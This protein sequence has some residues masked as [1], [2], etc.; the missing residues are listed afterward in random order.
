V[1]AVVVHGGLFAGNR[2]V[3]DTLAFALRG[4]A[5]NGFRPV[6]SDPPATLWARD[7]GTAERFDVQ[8]GP[9]VFCSGWR[10]FPLS[11]WAA[12]DRYAAFWV[13]GRALE[14]DVAAR[15]PISG[16]ISVDGKLELIDRIAEPRTLRF[17][18]GRAGWHL[19]AVESRALVEEFGKPVGIA[20]RAVRARR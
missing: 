17:E 10:F 2:F 15:V 8:P 12:R 13:Y 18:L 20:L 14:L 3:P 1:R 4:L 5:A 16:R 11:G 6:A 7:G 19:V 9:P